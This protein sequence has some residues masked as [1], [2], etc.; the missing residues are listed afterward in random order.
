MAL[1]LNSL[2]LFLAVATH[3]GFSRA[4]RLTGV[5]QPAISKAVRLLEQ[6]GGAQL[7]VRAPAGVVLT[8]AGRLLLEHARALFAE[9]RSAD[10]RRRRS[11]G[12]ATAC[13]ASARAP[14]CP[15]TS[16][17][18][19]SVSCTGPIRGSTSLSANA[20]AVLG[21]VLEHQVELGLVEGPVHD[22][23]LEVRPWR[24]DELLVVAA[25]G[26]PLT[27]K[28]GV[29]GAQLMEELLLLREEGAGTRDVTLAAL[30]RRRWTP[31]RSFE[32]NS[33]E[34]IKGLVAAG[35]GWAV[36]S[37]R[38]VRDELQVGRLKRIDVP[39]FALR[40]TLS[41]VR[42]RARRASARRRPPSGAWP[43]GSP[44]PEG[45]TQPSR[46]SIELG[47]GR[48]GALARLPH[49]KLRPE[50]RHLRFLFREGTWA[51]QA[52]GPDLRVEG[53]ITRRNGLRSARVRKSRTRPTGESVRANPAVVRP[54]AAE[55]DRSTEERRPAVP[56]FA[57][58]GDPIA[59]SAS[60]PCS[61]ARRP[62]QRRP[63]SEPSRPSRAP[64]CGLGDGG[65][66][67]WPL[68]RAV[69]VT[70]PHK[71]DA[72][73]LADRADPR[74]ARLGASELHRPMLRMAR[75]WPTTPTWRA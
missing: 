18:R 3:G 11:A 65:G 56:R 68:G 50:I 35:V 59:H 8:E 62:P 15:H 12:S 52:G 4:A 10:E 19:S 39:D 53:S 69:V 21:A 30:R 45:S 63:G 64:G 32:V 9:E 73:V 51:R 22:G 28:R 54:R 14:R 31:T 37:A 26:H 13:C 72:L 42:W 6:Q 24:E 41:W 33:T 46:H 20:R 23:R 25:P 57:V 1:N 67:R 61:V 5:S 40:R 66:A 17:R 16:C 7:L 36:L 27:R 74:A 47:Q 44:T 2:R 34:A 38:A 48:R 55:V 60:P 75:G 43:R 70:I 58:I 49:E 29:T 71:Q